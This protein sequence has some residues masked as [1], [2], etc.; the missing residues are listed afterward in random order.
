MHAQ[1]STELNNSRARAIITIESAPTQDVWPE[2]WDLYFE[3][4]EPLQELA[5]L[6]HL[7]PRDAFDELLADPRVTKLIAWVGARPVGLAMITNE[8]DLVPQISP[9]FLHARY[10]NEA[11][12]RA[13]FFG[14]MVL[15]SDS[16]RRS[17]VFA[18]LVAGMAQ[19]TAEASGVVVFDI[20]RHNMDSMELDRQI[21]SFTRW[22]P[23]STF[24]QIDEQKYFA[25]K[26][27]ARATSGLPV[28]PR[29]DAEADDLLREAARP[30]TR[31][32]AS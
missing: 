5:L 24:D 31:V 6:N 10:P 14:I 11:S 20:C 16:R 7:Y 29:A 17:A 32:P 28:S 1:R 3:A 26:I 22:F 19:I 2:L 9:P 12:R 25:A 18:R 21:G 13:V 15:V 4:F 27:P 8:L 30:L 23:G